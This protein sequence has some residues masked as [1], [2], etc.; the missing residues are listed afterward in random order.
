M[1]A[2]AGARG[3][4]VMSRKER[5]GLAPRLHRTNLVTRM[6]R[7]RGRGVSRRPR[8]NARE[9]WCATRGRVALATARLV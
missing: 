4:E 2:E 1:I 6:R 3:L 9:R 7:S 8:E 5:S